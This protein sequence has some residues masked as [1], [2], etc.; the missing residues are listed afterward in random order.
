[1][2]RGFVTMSMMEV[3][4]LEVIQLILTKRHTVTASSK[5][6]GLSCQHTS[7]LVGRYSKDGAE[8]LVSKNRGRLSDC[9]TDSA[10]RKAILNLVRDSCSTSALPWRPSS[11]TSSTALHS[12]GRHSA[13]G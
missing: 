2:A 6:L 10:L 13:A 11:F 4:R 3:D 9:T 12:M 7:L 5:R 8:A 1:M